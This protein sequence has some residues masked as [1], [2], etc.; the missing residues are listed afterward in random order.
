MSSAQAYAAQLQPVQPPVARVATPAAPAWN[1]R[2][3]FSTG[4]PLH[5][6]VIQNARNKGATGVAAL[7]AVIDGVEL[8]Q[9]GHPLD[10]RRGQAQ[11]PMRR[12]VL[13]S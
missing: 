3:I 10:H 8:V 13:V 4:A 5:A 6:Q 11:Q 7:G 12:R 1:L 2:E 9:A